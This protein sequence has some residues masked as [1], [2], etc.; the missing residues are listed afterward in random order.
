[1]KRSTRRI[2]RLGTHELTAH[3]LPKT[4]IPGSSWSAITGLIGSWAT[5]ANLGMTSRQIHERDAIRSQMLRVGRSASKLRSETSRASRNTL[6][7]LVLSALIPSWVGR[8]GSAPT[9]A[10]P[11][12]DPSPCGGRSLPPDR[13]RFWPR[14]NTGC[15]G[16][17]GKTRTPPRPATW[18]SSR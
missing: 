11:S 16:A 7:G 15:R 10:P 8:P 12:P 17:T 3:P 13:V 1:M 18:R 2:G 6:N 14:Q 4:L 9:S 5:A